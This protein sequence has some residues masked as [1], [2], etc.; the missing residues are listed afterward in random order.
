M[1]D[2]EMTD[3]SANSTLKGRGKKRATPAEKRVVTP[4][5][6]PA[7]ANSAHSGTD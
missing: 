3:T 4:K 7:E 2:C 6:K 1:A 5:A